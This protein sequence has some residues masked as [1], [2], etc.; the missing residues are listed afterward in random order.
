MSWPTLR[1]CCCVILVLWLLPVYSIA[2][3]HQ[4]DE[5]SGHTGHTGH[6]GES[7]AVAHLAEAITY[8]T[9]SYQD[10]AQIDASA[11]VAFGVFLRRAYPA[12]FSQLQVEPLA[13]HSLLLTWPGTDR[14]HAPVLFDAHYDVVPVEPGTHANWAHPPFAGVVADGFLWGRGALDDKVAVIATLEAIEALLVDGFKPERT[15][16]F[17][18][19]HDEEIG[20]D[21]GASAIAARL[22]Q[23]GVRLAYMVGEGGVMVDAYPLLPERSLAIVGLAEKAYL[24]LTLRVSGAGGHSSYPPQNNALVRLAD[25][26][27]ALH[28]QPFEPKLVSPV[29]DMLRTIAPHVGGLTG[30]LFDHQ[31]LG[32]PLII[33][34]MAKE[35]TANAMVRTTTAVTMMNAGI[36]ENVIPQEASA[37]VNFRLL[38]GDTPESVI[39]HVRSVIDDEQIVIESDEWLSSPPVADPAGPGFARIRAAVTKVLPDAVVA[40]GL[41]IATTDT[42]HYTGLTDDI[43]RF[44]PYRMHLDDA[45]SIHGTN[46]RIALPVVTQ[47]VA[48]SKALIESAAG[49]DEH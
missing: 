28:T 16:F 8:R 2:Q 40:P 29:T 17:S 19:S 39:A 44:H 47:A 14:T 7:T 15:L 18:F 26:L 41:V 11:F 35:R 33:S 31:W 30:F 4:P 10:R 46:E 12:V 9:V 49:P 22:A 13:E 37:K 45:P 36:K 3:D 1:R 6:A 48:I 5:R 20:G 27:S 42:P 34:T 21:G 38:P 24:T 23:R 25:A 32:K 43:Y